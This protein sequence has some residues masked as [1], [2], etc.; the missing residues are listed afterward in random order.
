MQSGSHDRRDLGSAGTVEDS[1]Y[2]SSNSNV[3]CEEERKGTV[4]LVL[5]QESGVRLESTWYVGH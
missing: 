5:N 3:K 4:L 2:V 1:T